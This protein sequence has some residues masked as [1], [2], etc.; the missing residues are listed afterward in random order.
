MKLWLAYVAV[1]SESVPMMLV[2]AMTRDMAETIATERLAHR[3]VPVSTE[4]RVVIVGAWQCS[5]EDF[6]RAIASDV[7]AEDV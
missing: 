7:E 2:T 5:E 4:R 3:R 1:G 6:A